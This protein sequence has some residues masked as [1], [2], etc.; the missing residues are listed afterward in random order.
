MRCLALDIFPIIIGFS[1]FH[2]LCVAAVSELPNE[3]CCAEYGKTK[4]A[5]LIKVSCNC[6]KYGF[7]EADIFSQS[8]GL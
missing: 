5:E 7:E 3:V 6:Y 4:H 1:N 2:D 8:T